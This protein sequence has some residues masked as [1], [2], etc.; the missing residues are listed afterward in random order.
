MVEICERSASR[1]QSRTSTPSIEDAPVCHVVGAVDQLGQRTLARAG[2]PDD[3][4]GLPWRS[5]ERDVLEDRVLA[6]A[7]TDVLEDDLA[8][9]RRAI[10]RLVLVEFGLL[11]H[12]RQ[13]ALG[14][15]DAKLDE[16]ETE[17]RDVGGEAQ[18][19]HQAEEGDESANAQ[20][21]LCDEPC[22]LQ[23]AT[24]KRHREQQPRQ[25][26]RLY[27][28]LAHEVVAVAA[29]VAR[30]LALLL[31]LLRGRLDD[32]DA[33]DRLGQPCI[34]HAELVAHRAADRAE[35]LVVADRRPPRR[36]R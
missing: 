36:R 12:D 18:Q 29:G 4:D 27:L 26:A 21:S 32:L 7:E 33:S 2:L 8:F 11:A 1:L 35:P 25:V 34:H 5:A 23:K 3:G 17:D 14:A 13:D 19:R 15:G 28:A 20:L 9:D 24:D 31:L 6:V 22:A 10:S 16:D 30:E